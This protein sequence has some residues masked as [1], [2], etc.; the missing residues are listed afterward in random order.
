MP[1][2]Q[3]SLV[4]NQERLKHAFVVL[5]AH[6]AGSCFVP[7]HCETNPGK[8]SNGTELMSILRT[9]NGRKKSCEGASSI[10]QKGSVLPTRVVGPGMCG[11]TLCS[12]RKRFFGF[13]AIGLKKHVPLGS[14]SCKGFILRIDHRS[15]SERK[16]RPP[17][18]SGSTRTVI[19]ESFFL[20]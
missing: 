7:T 20:T 3:F 16:W 8:S 13:T 10:F 4:E 1:G 6:I 5:T 9:A 11:P 18:T 15:S 19:S 12:G 17:G 14:T 2:N